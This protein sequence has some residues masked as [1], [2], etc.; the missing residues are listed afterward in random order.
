MRNLSELVKWLT[1]EGYKKEALSVNDLI[2]HAAYITHKVVSGDTLIGIANKYEVDVEDIQRANDMGSDTMIRA[3]QP[4]KIMR[5]PASDDDIVAMTL[6]GEGGTAHG[7]TIMKEVFTVIKNRS[8]CLGISKK[9]VVLK[10]SQFSYWNSRQPDAVFYGD[11]G[12]QHPLFDKALR[13]VEEGKISSAV[14]ASTHYYVKSE[15]VPEKYRNYSDKPV[16]AKDE[17]WEEIYVGPQH[18]YGISRTGRYKKCQSK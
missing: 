12:K 13:I 11:H 1:I 18:V 10:G 6:L 17:E 14:G 7:E 16:W 2:K 4:L 5:T 9:D 15:L 3:G 8:D